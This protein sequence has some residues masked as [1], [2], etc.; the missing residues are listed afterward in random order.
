M[1]IVNDALTASMRR[2]GKCRW[3]GR[4]VRMLCGAHIFAKGHGSGRQIDIPC[5]LVSLG[6]D[7]VRDC[8]CHHLNHNGERPTTI[9]LLAVSAADHDCLQSDIE[10][11]KDLILRMPKFKEMT[12]ERYEA[13]VK[14]TLS[15]SARRLAMGQ[16]ES[17]R[18]LLS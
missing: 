4:Q 7:A 9:D 3:C 13:I 12:P 11:L 8:L 15:F 14:R 2:P 1:K 5:N 18:H 16:L 17:F 6:D 10:E